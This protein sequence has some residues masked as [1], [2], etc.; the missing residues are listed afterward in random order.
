MSSDGDMDRQPVSS[1]VVTS[2]GYDSESATLEVE[3]VSGSVY[4]Y[5]DVPEHLHRE[6][7]AGPSAGKMM[8]SAIIGKFRYARL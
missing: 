6:L 5:F 2:V 3:F 1:T 8:T 4:Q 7:I